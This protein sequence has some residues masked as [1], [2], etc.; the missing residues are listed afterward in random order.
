ML[1]NHGRAAHQEVPHFHLHLFGGRDLGPMLRRQDTGVEFGSGRSTA[2]FAARVARLTSVEHDAEWHQAV[3][4][5]LRHLG[6]GNVDYVLAPEDQPLERGGE[7]AYARTALAFADA[8]IDFA[9]VDGHYRDYSARLILPKIR[10]G[11]MLIVDNA[12]LYLKRCSAE[13]AGRYRVGR[14]D[15]KA[16]ARFALAL[17]SPG[18]LFN[19][20]GY[21]KQLM[22]NSQ[23]LKLVR[24]VL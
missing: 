21:V 7:S 23:F 16:L 8:S 6:L 18:V 9:L 20:E 24:G 15:G 13:L 19:W 1:A 22:L 11:G 2:W 12:N 3:A 14:L 17:D 4:A 10:P 5:R